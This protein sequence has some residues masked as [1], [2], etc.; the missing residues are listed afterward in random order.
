[1]KVACYSSDGPG[2]LIANPTAP[3]GWV[4]GYNDTYIF[5]ILF[6]ILCCCLFIFRSRSLLYVIVLLVLLLL[7]LLFVENNVLPYP[8]NHAQWYAFYDWLHNWDFSFVTCVVFLMDL[9][10]RTALL[11]RLNNQTVAVS[12]EGLAGCDVHIQNCRRSTV[13]LMAPIRSVTSD[14]NRHMYVLVTKQTCFIGRILCTIIYC[15]DYEISEHNRSSTVK[16]TPPLVYLL[17]PQR[18]NLYPPLRENN[19][20]IYYLYSISLFLLLQDCAGW[21]VFSLFAGFGSCWIDCGRE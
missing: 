21:K 10:C 12:E 6:P 18:N 4:Q 9:R 3:K 1:M 19:L 5:L 11:R 16:D 14:N 2:R 8:N 7:L 15:I 20:V 13:Y 17:T